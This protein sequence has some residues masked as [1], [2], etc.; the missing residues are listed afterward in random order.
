MLRNIKSEDFNRVLK[1]QE[2]WSFDIE[3][4]GIYVLSIS[5]KCKN[6]LQNFKRLFNDDDL[7]IQID[8]YLFAEIKGKKR[9]FFT[10][11]SWNGNEL[12]NSSKKI[13]FLLPIRKG[14]HQIKF[15]TD[16][17]PFLE[18]IEIYYQDQ[19]EIILNEVDLAG[20]RFL[21]ILVKNLA[22]EEAVIK[23]KTEV[24]SKLELRIDG[25]TQNNPKYQRYK[26][27]YW[28]GKELQD[29]I[30]EFKLNQCWISGIHS[31]EFRGEGEPKIESISIKIGGDK[32]R[33][34]I[35]HVKLWDDIVICDSV[36]LRSE[37]TTKKGEILEDLYDGDELEIVEERVVGEYQENRSE[38][39][40]KVIYEDKKGFVLSSFVE[41][42]GQERE[43]AIDLIKEKCHQYDVD[44]NIMLAIA[45][46]ESHFKPYARSYTGRQGIFQLGLKA[47]EQ[48]GVLDRYDFY[49]NIEGGVKYYKWLEKNVKGRGNILEKRLVGWHSGRDYVINVDKIDYASLPLG[50]DAKKFVNS[51]FEN[52]KRKDWFRIIW[53]PTIILVGLVGFF[54]GMLYMENQAPASILFGADNLPIRISHY[55]RINNDIENLSLKATGKSTVFNEG[56]AAIN[57]IIVRDLRDEDMIPYTELIYWSDKGEFHEILSGYFSSAGWVYFQAGDRIFW[58]EREEGKYLPST[59][60]LPKDGRLLKIKFLEENG[61]MWDERSGPFEVRN[62]LGTP[63]FRELKDGA[64]C[65]SDIKEYEYD[66]S[67]NLFR[68]IKQETPIKC[69]D[70]SEFQG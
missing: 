47:A 1:D 32:I 25:K 11:G 43:K 57:K 8:D 67:E 53:L 50:N 28:Y 45:G 65:F 69:L 59:L 20:A 26:K 49:Q 62:L 23:A 36:Y 14:A 66:Y 41:V 34:K 29:G 42:E 2:I 68:E 51:V 3:K 63:I 12:K 56:Y 39:W 7:A 22:V 19:K 9:E 35:G 44:A 27:W 6:W 46:V 61:Y 58:I 40:H 24:N 64:K 18:K 13:I 10:P 21:D 5:A 60:Y 70:L 16:G 30:K 15:W 38:I 33:Y 54:E 17:K 55:S 4:D 48:E 31:L 52:I 37:P